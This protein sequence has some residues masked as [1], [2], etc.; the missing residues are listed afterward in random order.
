MPLYEYICPDCGIIEVI[1]KFS[2]EPLKTCPN[3]EKQ[4][5]EKAISRSAFHLKG[6]GWYKTDYASPTTTTSKNE[7]TK[8]SSSATKTEVS[9][10]ATDTKK[11]SGSGGC[12]SGCGCH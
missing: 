1:Q 3:C 11:N 4:T 9:S 10:S 2:D 7:S 5:V 6:G 12:G 8:E